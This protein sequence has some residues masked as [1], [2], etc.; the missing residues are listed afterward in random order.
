[1]AGGG[2]RRERATAPTSVRVVVD[3]SLS[4]SAWR[5]S[6]GAAFVSGILKQIANVASQGQSVDEDACN[7]VLGWLP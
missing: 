4:L 7:F 2:A 6:Y 1:M 3:T 5:L